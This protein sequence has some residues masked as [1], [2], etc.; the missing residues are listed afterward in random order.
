M[1]D[2]A[3]A[4]EIVVALRDPTRYTG[5]F[6]WEATCMTYAGKK[7]KRRDVIVQLDRQT[8]EVLGTAVRGG[9]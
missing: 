4:D 7:S 5:A 2:G 9:L 1:L 8:G 6:V 3:A